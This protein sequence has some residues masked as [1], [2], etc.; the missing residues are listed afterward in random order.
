MVQ[1]HGETSSSAGMS[2]AVDTMK[3]IAS[4]QLNFTISCTVLSTVVDDW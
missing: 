2:R 1:P 4:Y 3:S